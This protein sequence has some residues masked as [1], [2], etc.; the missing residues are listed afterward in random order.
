[1]IILMRHAEVIMDN[2]PIYAQ[3]MASFITAYDEGKIHKDVPMDLPVSDIYVCSALKRSVESLK[4][5]GYEPQMIDKVFN[6][7]QLPYADMKSFKLSAKIWAP[8][9]R[10]AWLFGYSNHSE[11]YSDAKKRAVS[12]AE[13]LM[14]YDDGN[15]KVML[16]G[17]GVMNRLILK[18]LKN[19]R[20]TVS[21]KTGSGNWGYLVLEPKE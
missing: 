19:R 12:A 10:I 14:Q 3:E 5:M 4:L 18:V 16:M 7:A 1:M 20:Y 11:S 6:E 8:L 21:K 13:I 15:K 17:H 2:K 9:F